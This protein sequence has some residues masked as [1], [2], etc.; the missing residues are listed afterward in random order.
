[1]QLRLRENETKIPLGQASGEQL[2]R[3]DRDHR[4]LL[5]TL[6][7]K[8]RDAAFVE[9][10]V[11]TIPKKRLTVGTNSIVTASPVARRHRA[12]RGSMSDNNLLGNGAEG[13]SIE[14]R[15]RRADPPSGRYQGD[16]L[17]ER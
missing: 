8:V 13:T 6:G 9:V 10:H 15:C 11:I 12:K 3:R 7:V 2:R 16:R 1:M 14:P 17:L 5:A 4:R